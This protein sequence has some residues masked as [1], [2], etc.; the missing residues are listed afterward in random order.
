[1]NVLFHRQTDIGLQE[2]EGGFRTE[3]FTASDAGDID[4]V[5]MCADLNRQVETF[6]NL[7]SGWML[8]TI[9]RFIIHIGEYRPFAGSSF[10]PTPKSLAVKKA[11]INVYNIDDDK[12]FAWAVLSA[13]YPCEHHA[14]RLSK[15]LPYFNSINLS[16]IKFPTPIN[17]INRFEK[18][19]PSISI[20]VYTFEK[21]EIIPKHITKCGQRKKH[22]DLLLLTSN[23]TSH[24]VWIKNMSALVCGRTK[25]KCKV[26]VCPHCVHPFRS[27]K[28]FDN[29][30]PDC[31]KHVYQKTKYPQPEKNLLFWKSRE[32]TE[33][34]P[35]VIYADFESCLVPVGDDT[36][37]HIPAGFCAYT[38]STNPMY[39]TDPFLYSGVDCMAVFFDH[40]A[41][42]QERIASILD[43]NIPMLPLTDEEKNKYD[44]A[45]ECPKCHKPFSS[46]NPKVRHHNHSTGRFIGALCN[47]CNLQIRNKKC[48]FV[49]PVVFHNLKNYDAHHIFKYFNKETAD[50][51]GLQKF[52]KVKILAVTMEKYISFNIQHLRF[53]DSCQF[54]NASLEKLVN[55]LA[56]DAFRHVNRYLGNDPLL[57]AKGIFPYE[58]FDSFEKFDCTELPTKEKFFSR[59]NDE[60][61]TEEEYERAKKV[62]TLFD[63]HTFKDYHDLYLKTD[64]LLLADV[65]EN[66]RDVALNTYDLDPAHYVTTPSLAWDACL[67]YTDIVLELITDPEIHVFVESGMRGGISVISNRYARA[68]NPYLKPEDYDSSQPH[69][70]IC[71]LDANNLYGWAMSQSLPT[72]G[73]RFLDEDEIDEM[74]FTAVPDDSRLGY[75]VECDLEYPAELHGLHNDYPLAPEHVKITEDM[76]SPYCKSINIKSTLTEKLIGDLKTKFKYKVH[77]RN[78]KLYL[79]L[80]MKLIKIHRVLEFDQ[81]AW[82]KPYIDLNTFMRQ[83]AKS[84]FEKDFFKLMNNAVFGKSMENVRKRRNIQLVSNPPVLRKLLTKPQL[85]QFIIVNRDTVLVDRIRKKVTLNKPI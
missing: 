84:D 12:C 85:E 20:N 6:T 54:L 52:Q 62:W 41:K 48:S 60:G 32:K 53:I 77:Y 8:T 16:G 81:K 10:I 56:R 2:T 51:Y 74:D 21:N 50:K 67:K 82:L 23:Q 83:Q 49:L 47:S 15:Y 64:V 5:E 73:F 1:M 33:R 75:I 71:Y 9:L 38:V 31:S 43:V 25:H 13:L 61:I 37:E 7:G 22:I 46:T 24:Y 4:F 26:Y 35:F 29:H 42:E 69:S 28:A 55:S 34:L 11:I 30:L 70:Y 80:G 27:K 36:D 78:L 18:N 3:V 79:S 40:M 39:A 45:Q 59:L 68:N 44:L 57:F 19:N 65:F 76:V 63:C 17:Q 72:G 66:F 14:E 58:W